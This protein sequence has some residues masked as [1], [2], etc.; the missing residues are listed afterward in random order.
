MTDWLDDRSKVERRIC[1]AVRSGLN[2]HGKDSPTVLA[3]AIAKRVYGELKA[4]RREHNAR[5]Q[6]ADAQDGE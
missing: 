5:G 6:Q 2:D 1:S 3:A 4:L